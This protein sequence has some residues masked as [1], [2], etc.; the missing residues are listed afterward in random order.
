[1][2]LVTIEIGIL[3]VLSYSKT[4]LLLRPVTFPAFSQIYRNRHV[5]PHVEWG[6]SP[7]RMKSV[8]ALVDNL[9]LLRGS[10]VPCGGDWF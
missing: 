10:L 1:M 9:C 5:F 2:A 4:D 3:K 7:V 8:V 6:L